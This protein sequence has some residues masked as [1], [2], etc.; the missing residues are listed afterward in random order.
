[1]NNTYNIEQAFTDKYG[2]SFIS[3]VAAS[4]YPNFGIERVV[5]RETQISGVDYYFWKKAEGRQIKHKVDLKLDFY[6]NDNFALE[7]EQQYTG[8]GAESWLWHD[9][10][11]WICYFK[12]AQRKCYVYKLSDLQE[13]T[14][15]DVYKNRKEMKTIRTVNGKAGTF[16]NFR[17]DELPIH[18]I[19]DISLFVN[20]FDTDEILKTKRSLPDSYL[21]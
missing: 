4:F 12:V 5:D 20:P 3:Q 6:E 9:G 16:K 7:T 2:D 1:M 13:F 19:V 8:K 14:N 10:N 17:L 18:H 21:Y 11:I 15:T